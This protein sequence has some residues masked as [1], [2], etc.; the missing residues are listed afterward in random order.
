MVVVWG[1]IRGDLGLMFKYKKIY[2]LNPQIGIMFISQ[3]SFDCAAFPFLF[4]NWWM[5]LWELL[6]F[7][8]FV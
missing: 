6:K 7:Q 3:N 8:F 5:S 1:G 4:E 2:E